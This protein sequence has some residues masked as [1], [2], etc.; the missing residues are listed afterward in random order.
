M[1]GWP[2]RR[3]AAPCLRRA[4]QGQRPWP[5]SGFT[6]IEVLVVLAIL[7]VILVLI[8]LRGPQRSPG[9]VLRS[10]AA[11]VRGALAGARGEAIANDRDVAVG[12]AVDPAALA[13]GGRRRL[14]LPPGVALAMLTGDGKPEPGT[15]IFRFHP[16]GSADGGG[17]LVANEAGSL[18]VRVAWLTGRITVSALPHAD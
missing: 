16:D 13:V 9:F 4:A 3:S 18:A 1:M 11:L 17:V 10:E 12:L 15:A 8:L 14:M 7:G 5:S 2:K 6:L